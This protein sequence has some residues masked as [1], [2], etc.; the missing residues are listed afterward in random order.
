MTGI[1]F[2]FGKCD[3]TVN[4]FFVA[5]FGFFLSTAHKDNYSVPTCNAP[6]KHKAIC[7]RHMLMVWREQTNRDR[8]HRRTAA[9]ERVSLPAT[10]L[11]AGPQS[12]LNAFV[13]FFWI[14]FCFCFFCNDNKSSW[15]ELKERERERE[16]G[17]EREER[18]SKC[19]WKDRG[20]RRDICSKNIYWKSERQSNCSCPMTRKE[21]KG[22][23]RKTATTNNKFRS[24]SLS[25]ST[26]QAQIEVGARWMHDSL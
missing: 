15:L 22:L 13:L 19:W 24:L 10:V 4:V 11:Y 5:F 2:S 20:I 26:F 16:R 1:L 17:R 12:V 3:A 18:Q 14:V 21:I 6:H 9:G 23:G 8:W 25:F 7:I